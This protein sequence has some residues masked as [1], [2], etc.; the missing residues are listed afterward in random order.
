MR[1]VCTL[2]YHRAH[3]V[4]KLVERSMQ[5]LF[6]VLLGLAIVFLAYVSINQYVFGQI[7]LAVVK[8]SSMEPLLKDR[9]IV[10]LEH[11]SE[12]E[13][14]DIVV[15]RN[16]YNEL[17]VH[18]VVAIIRCVDGRVLYVTKGDNNPYLDTEV[19][20]IARRSSIACYAESVNVISSL[21]INALSI[22][23]DNI[24]RGLTD[25]RIV[26]KVLEI[27]GTPLKITG[28]TILSSG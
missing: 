20:G 14:G 11:S 22:G 28:L 21:N 24:V 12:I 8:G 7:V 27:W 6:E 23:K 17:V 5:L 15:Y 9:D 3:K 25:T 2:G 26:G 4:L 16:D 10:V 19:L 1:R 13:L 18:R